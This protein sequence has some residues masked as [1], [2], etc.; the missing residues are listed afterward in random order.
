MGRLKPKYSELENN[1][2][3]VFDVETILKLAG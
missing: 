2:K 3:M 1:K